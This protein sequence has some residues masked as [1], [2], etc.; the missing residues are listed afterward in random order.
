MTFYGTPGRFVDRRP[1]NLVLYCSVLRLLLL[2]SP[3]AGAH[4]IDP[5]MLEFGINLDSA[6]MVCNRLCMSVAEH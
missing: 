5:L 1:V 2:F 6:V 3:K 4:F